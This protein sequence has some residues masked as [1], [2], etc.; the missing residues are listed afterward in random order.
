MELFILFE[1]I[2]TFPV[3]FI[4]LFYCGFCHFRSKEIPESE[5]LSLD[6]LRKLSKRLSRFG[7]FLV[8]TEGG[9]PCLP[10]DLVDIVQEFA[11]YMKNMH[12]SQLAC[13]FYDSKQVKYTL[14]KEIG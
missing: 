11:R 1:K 6:E 9:E 3:Y 7:C 10:P 2:G 5:E 4:F 12:E 13:S 8:S 14:C